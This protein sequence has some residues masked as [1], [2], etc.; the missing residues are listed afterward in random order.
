MEWISVKDMEP[1]E[2]K[3]V[4]VLVKGRVH[5]GYKHGIFWMVPNCKRYC[6]LD[7]KYWMPLPEPPKEE[8]NN[9]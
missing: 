6:N 8:E 2:D 9:D 1:K 5:E 3:N 4:L 7:V